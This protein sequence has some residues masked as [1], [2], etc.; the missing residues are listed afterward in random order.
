MAARRGGD[1]LARDP[2][3]HAGE[4]ERGRRRDALQSN[5]GQAGIAPPA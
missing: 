4:V 2:A 1:R 3:D 5:L